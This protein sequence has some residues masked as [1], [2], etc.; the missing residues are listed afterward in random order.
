MLLHDNYLG[1]L[2]RIEQNDYY[3][4]VCLTD[5]FSK[6]HVQDIKQ[7]KISYRIELRKG[8]CEELNKFKHKLMTN[9]CKL[10]NSVKCFAIWRIIRS[11]GAIEQF[12]KTARDVKLSFLSRSLKVINPFDFFHECSLL[13]F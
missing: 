1:T 10:T 12:T 8:G 6:T 3:E 9:F 2:E 4:K 7:N 13:E 5:F 11:E